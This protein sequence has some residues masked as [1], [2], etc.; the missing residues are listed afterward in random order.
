MLKCNKG[1]AGSFETT[2][3]LTEA[4]VSF[5]KALTKQAVITRH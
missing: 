3:G 1:G 5:P 4:M 2:C